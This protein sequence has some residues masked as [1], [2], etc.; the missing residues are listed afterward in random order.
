MSQEVSMTKFRRL[1]AAGVIACSLGLSAQAKT[2]RV[3]VVGDPA[4]M[5]PITYSEIT[6]GRIMKNVYEGFTDVTPEGKIVPA[7]AESWEP[8]P[9]GP[10]FRFHLRP[11]VLFHSGR[12]FSARDV[13][14]TF[15]ELLRPGGRGGVNATYLDGVVGAKEL[16]AG[17]ATELAG[18]RIVDDTTLDV[19]FIKPGRAVPDL[20]VHVHG[21]RDGR[22]A[23]AGLDDTRLRRHR[24]LQVPPM[25]A[26]RFRRSGRQQGVLGGAPKID[27]V[28]FL[29]VPS[30]DTSLAQFDA[31][32]LDFVDVFR[33]RVPPR[34]ARRALQEPSHPGAARAIHLPRHEPEP[35]SAVPRQAGA[36]GGFAR[37]RPAGHD[38]RSVWRGRVPIERR[39]HAGDAGLRPDLAGAEIRPRP[40]ARADGGGGFPGG[41]GLP[42]VDI[43]STD[44]FKDEIT[45]YANQ[46][47]RVL[48]MPVSVKVVE[49]ATHIRAM[50]AG[51]VAF[52]PWGWTADY[53]DAL[54]YLSQ[55]WYGPSPYNRARWKNAEYDALIEQA[56]TVADNAARYAIYA[57]AERV[58]MNDWGMA[59]VPMPASIALRKPNV[60]NVTLTPFG[61]STFKDIVI[62]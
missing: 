11:G 34:I 36:R 10:G 35:V 13:K 47:N 57:K 3:N 33:F 52:F 14:Y 45:Y 51:E 40:G 62:D 24:S 61:F 31:G 8:L 46:F 21:Q 26:G 20:P 53:P 22:R 16:R 23:G 55:M 43:T 41:K 1:L 19:A 60:H 29:I 42:P 49:R 17:T 54:Y 15:E 9:S 25:A 18:A 4:Q 56:Q 30:A 12:K 58:L 59:P 6:S 27:G 32:E 7:L 44:A 48:G 37:H 50:N 5:D 2:F 28:S 39:D 38:T